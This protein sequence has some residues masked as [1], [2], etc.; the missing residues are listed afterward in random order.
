MGAFS[1]SPVAVDA[2][3]AV[4][5]GLGLGLKGNFVAES[6]PREPEDPG[7]GKAPSISGLCLVTVASFSLGIVAD[8]DE[9]GLSVKNLRTAEGDVADVVLIGEHPGPI[10]DDIWWLPSVG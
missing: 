2:I 1:A 4:L 6:P 5:D 7:D 3:G 8:P 10:G 9:V